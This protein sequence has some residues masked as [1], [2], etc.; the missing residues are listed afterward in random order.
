MVER[1]AARRGADLPA[2]KA[3]AIAAEPSRPMKSLGAAATKLMLWPAKKLF[4]KVFVVFAV[5]EGADQVGRA[6]ALGYLVDAAIE[7]GWMTR[8]D[9]KALRLAIDAVSARVGTSPVVH[10]ASLAFDQV[11]TAIPDLVERV[12][13]MMAGKSK[14]SPEATTGAVGEAFEREI[15]AVSPGYFDRLVSELAREL[16]EPDPFAPAREIPVRA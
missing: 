2:E 10:A 11:K 7:H 6:Y 4:R 1:I 13:R 9:P 14:V 12:K 5:K 8:H 16:S 15:R 3:K